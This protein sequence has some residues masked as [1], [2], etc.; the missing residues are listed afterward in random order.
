MSKDLLNQFTEA[1]ADPSSV[2]VEEL[3]AKLRT[4]EEVRSQIDEINAQLKEQN[5]K[6]AELEM[7]VLDMFEKLGKTK[8]FLDGVGTISTSTRFSVRVPKDMDSKKQLLQYIHDKYG[9]EAYWDYA[10]VNS[11]KLNAFFKEELALA[12]ESGDTSF[13]L[14]GVGAPTSSQSLRLL[15]DKKGK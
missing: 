12:E 7:Q 6:K 13:Q 10:T 15:R 14:P 4:Y 2:S 5:Q 8:Y 11:A 3:E 9:P 1:Q